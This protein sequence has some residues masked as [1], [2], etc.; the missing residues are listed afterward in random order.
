[1]W[2]RSA[3]PVAPRAVPA[4]RGAVLAA[5][6]TAW[7][8]AGP[9]G[10]AG[11][12]GAGRTGCRSMAGAADRPAA[13]WCPGVP[14]ADRAEAGGGVSLH[15]CQRPP[16]YGPSA[17]CPGAPISANPWCI[18]QHRQQ[19]GETTAIRETPNFSPTGAKTWHPAPTTGWGPHSGAGNR[20]G[21]ALAGM[22]CIPLLPVPLPGN[23]LPAGRGPRAGLG[24]GVRG[25]P[26]I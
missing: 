6:G 12:A 11:T 14:P 9:S 21:G 20:G 24:W 16:G 19:V 26:G 5:G 7:A 25:F 15:P 13:C 17:G 2:P 10:S 23:S 1:M 8:G 4:G 18:P 22:C 3:A